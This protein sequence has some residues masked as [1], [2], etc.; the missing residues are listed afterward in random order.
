MTTSSTWK[1]QTTC[2]GIGGCG[3][4]ILEAWQPWLPEGIQS[5]AINSDKKRLDKETAIT[6]KIFLVGDSK[7]Q[8]QASMAEHMSELITTLG[9]REHIILLAGLGGI[10]GTWASQLICNHMLS[11][12]KQV[13]TVLVQ[14]FTFEGERVKIAQSS[15]SGFDTKANSILC[16]NS[17]IS[18]LVPGN[19]SL[20][21]TFTIMHKKTFDLLF[22]IP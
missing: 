13:V 1:E 20:K 16:Y 21:D 8:L 2:I 14:P 3:M 17:E 12:G 19:T 18:K 7:K 11:I 6:N 5:V 4:N 15:L 10:S 22:K 9:G